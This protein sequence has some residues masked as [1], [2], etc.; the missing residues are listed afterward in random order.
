M[1]TT[2]ALDL[3]TFRV[4]IADLWE[5]RRMPWTD[6]DH[7]RIC[8]GCWDQ[9]GMPIP[10][11]MKAG[12]PPIGFSLAS[13]GASMRGDMFVPSDLVEQCIAMALQLKMMGGAGNGKPGGL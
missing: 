1:S 9:M 12:L 13:E 4:I 3:V 6:G 10:I 5:S 2:F 7:A 8:R 11:S